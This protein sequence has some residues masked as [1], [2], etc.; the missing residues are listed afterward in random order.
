MLLEARWC[1]EKRISKALCVIPLIDSVQEDS[2]CSC[3]WQFVLLVASAT[4]SC[5]KGGLLVVVQAALRSK[6]YRLG[7]SGF[8]FLSGCFIGF[9]AF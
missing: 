6:N 5:T 9:T 1:C 7:G 2:A 8:L 3:T 4:C